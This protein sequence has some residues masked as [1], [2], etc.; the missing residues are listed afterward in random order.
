MNDRIIK[1]LDRWFKREEINGNH[2][3][4]TYLH[5]WIL[6]HTPWFAVY[7]HRF[8]GQDWSYDL[9]DHPKRFLSLGLH[10][11][12]FEESRARD[13]RIRSKAWYAPWFRSFPAH[14]AHRIVVLPPEECWTICITLWSVRDWGFWSQEGWILWKDYVRGDKSHLA[15]AR[16]A[17]P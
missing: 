1:V 12:Y 8:I 7:V 5:R 14:H 11:W 9:H 2:R 6:F 16:K 13:G 4:P 17:C 10:G 15:D 3:C